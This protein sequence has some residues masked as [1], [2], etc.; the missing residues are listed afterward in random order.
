MLL[1]P[2][3]FEFWKHRLEELKY[4]ARMR[5]ESCGNLYDDS[6]YLHEL[7]LRMF[8]VGVDDEPADQPQIVK[9]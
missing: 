4:R 8:E 3:L 1:K 7:V 2:R 5:E 9:G 6:I